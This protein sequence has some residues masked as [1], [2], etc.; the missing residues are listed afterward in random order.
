MP[1]RRVTIQ[2]QAEAV[3]LSPYFLMNQHKVAD[4]FGLPI[5]TFSKRWRYA[6]NGRLW[7]YRRVIRIDA[8]LKLTRDETER[9]RLRKERKRLMKPVWMNLN[10]IKKRA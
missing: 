9:E 5:S 2:A 10:V 8:D 6:A 3:D 7:P 1:C 4:M